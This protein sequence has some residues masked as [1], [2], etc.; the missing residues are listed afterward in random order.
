[1]DINIINEKRNLEHKKLGEKYAHLLNKIQAKSTDGKET[2][3]IGV[4]LF[5]SWTEERGY[6]KE[7]T[8]LQTLLDV[9]SIRTP[10][11]VFTLKK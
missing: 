10:W 1:M 5:L 11:F 3:L 4:E 9:G 2:M 6:W 8:A 7:G